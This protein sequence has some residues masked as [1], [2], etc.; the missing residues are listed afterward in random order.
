[1]HP[2]AV[3]G[4]VAA[5]SSPLAA[6]ERS[7]AVSNAPP[8][9]LV[10]RKAIEHARLD[11]SEITSWKKR[12]RLAPLLP[13]LQVSYE[14]RIKNVVDVDV[15]DSVY[16]GSGGSA[17]GPPEGSYA[18]NANL[19]ND[20]GVKAVWSLNE[21]IFNPDMLAVSEEARMLARERQAILAEVNKNYYERDRTAGEIG[22]L[23]EQQRQKPRDEKIR[24]EIFMKRVAIDE[25]VAALDALTGGWFGGQIKQ[26]GPEV[27]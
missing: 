11:P 9:A 21:T 7:P 17:V 25:A 13:K 19:D 26:R 10:Q 20:I 2:F 8:I 23:S 22:F 6:P 27:P 3:I 16:V 4:L 15:N 14:R 24:Q 1:M 18:A 12:A 5:L